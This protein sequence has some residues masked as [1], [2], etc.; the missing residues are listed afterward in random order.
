MNEY[1]N[2]ICV[3]GTDGPLQ[4]FLLYAL[5]LPLEDDA[6]SQLRGR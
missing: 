5:T 4:P 1:G 2:A 6:F 3:E